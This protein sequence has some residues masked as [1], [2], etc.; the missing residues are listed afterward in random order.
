MIESKVS[1]SRSDHSD[2]L[3]AGINGACKMET[4]L[5]QT[6]SRSSLITLYFV[7]TVRMS[8]HDLAELLTSRQLNEEQFEPLISLHI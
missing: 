7:H 4:I 5:K 8:W 6:R 3:I 1:R 2:L